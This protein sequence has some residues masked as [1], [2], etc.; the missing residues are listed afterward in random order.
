[1]ALARIQAGQGDLGQ[2]R[3]SLLMIYEQ[4]TE[5]FETQD[6]KAAEQLLRELDRT[7]DPHISID[8]EDHVLGEPRSS[9]AYLE[10]RSVSDASSATQRVD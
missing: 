4:F 5:G 6:L 1:M 7:Q 2:A 8:V 9:A 10:P 3:Q